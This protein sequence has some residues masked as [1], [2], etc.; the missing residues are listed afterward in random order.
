MYIYSYKQENTPRSV[1]CQLLAR[2]GRVVRRGLTYIREIKYVSRL[3]PTFRR[4]R[5]F[6]ATRGYA[7]QSLQTIRLIS[8]LCFLRFTHLIKLRGLV[9]VLLFTECI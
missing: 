9:L 6:R 8:K 3:R 4:V 2:K 1:S 7:S 5:I